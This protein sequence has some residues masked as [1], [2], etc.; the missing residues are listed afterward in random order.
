[1]SLDVK[2]TAIDA[3]LRLQFTLLLLYNLL[4]IVRV[5]GVERLMRFHLLVRHVTLTEHADSIATLFLH[6]LLFEQSFTMF[7][8][9]LALFIGQFNRSVRFCV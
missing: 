6:L 9:L 5:D 1:M 7:L 2:A 3:D 8:D 4:L